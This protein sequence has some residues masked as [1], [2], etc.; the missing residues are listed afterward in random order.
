MN[1]LTHEV[2]NTVTMA[3]KRSNTRAIRI[4]HPVTKK[5]LSLDSIPVHWIGDIQKSC[6]MI[7]LFEIIK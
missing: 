3:P 5:S 7:F 4:T 2:K 1:M 6:G